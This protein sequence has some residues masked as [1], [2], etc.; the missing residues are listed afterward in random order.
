MKAVEIKSLYKTFKDKVAINHVDLVVNE[1]EI[2]GL[3]GPN[4]A[5]KS[6]LINILSMLIGRDKGEVSIWG[7]SIDHNPMG[8]KG[9]LGVVPQDLAI[10][11]ELNAY[12]NVKFFGSLYGFRG[13][14]LEEKTTEALQ[15]VGL[16]DRKKDKAKTFSGGMKRRLNIACGIVHKPKLII[17]DEPTVGIDPQSRNYIL[18][19]IK[20]LNSQGSTI[21]Y[22]THYMEEAQ[23]L[24]ERIA[25]VDRGSVIAIGT[26]D[27]LEAL[28]DDK[29]T[30][31]IGVKDI[32]TVDAEKIQ[33]VKGVDKVKIDGNSLS[34]VSRKEVTNLH[35]ILADL[36]AT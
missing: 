31:Q 11:E 4:G 3:L 27:E 7:E 22:T 36:V 8:I 26:T 18:E 29:S 20:K 19:S 6:T 12:E 9:K 5:G 15:F 21:I 24:C 14:E 34:V 10:F 2:F 33:K 30:V 23:S 17:M 28:I 32:T 35:Q 25:I 1:G 16:L 13:K